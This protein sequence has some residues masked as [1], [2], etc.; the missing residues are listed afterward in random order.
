MKDTERHE[1]FNL[2]RQVHWL[3]SQNHEN[4]LANEEGHPHED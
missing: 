4:V 1:K 3:Q 2:D